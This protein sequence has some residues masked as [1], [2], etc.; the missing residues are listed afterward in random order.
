V[1]ASVAKFAPCRKSDPT[2]CRYG[3][4]SGSPIACAVDQRTLSYL[5]R[6]YQKRTDEEKVRRNARAVPRKSM[7][8]RPSEARPAGFRKYV[9]PN[10]PGCAGNAAQKPP[11]SELESPKLN[12]AGNLHCPALAAGQRQHARRSHVILI[13]GEG[14]DVGA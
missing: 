11:V 3:L 6:I 2:D 8:S 12:T 1:D 13:V 5:V 14:I 4:S 10:G 9:I 7:T